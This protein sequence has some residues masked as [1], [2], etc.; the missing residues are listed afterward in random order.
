[1]KPVL[2]F[3]FIFLTTTSTPTVAAFAMNDSTP[4]STATGTTPTTEGWS[5]VEM[6]TVRRET[7]RTRKRLQAEGV[8]GIPRAVS[9]RGQA[10][11][12]DSVNHESTLS[13]PDSTSTTVVTKTIHFQRHGQGYHN[14]VCEMWRE[15]GQP[16]NLDSHDAALNPMKRLEVMDAPLTEVGRQ[17]C[18]ARSAQASR[19][20]PEIMVVSPLLRTL[21]TAQLS[22]GAAHHRAIPWVAHEGCREDLGVL[23]CNKRQTSS[24][25]QS[26]YPNV[27]FSLLVDEHDTL[28]L[29][30][31]HE[32]PLEKATRIYEFLL[33]L[34]D[35]P[36]SEIAVVTHSS[37]LFCMCNAVMEIDD[38]AW[39]RWFF[40]SE[41]RSMQVSF[42]ET[43]SLSES[44]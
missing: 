36:Q 38:D 21:Q 7:A 30:N 43:T 13:P 3:A 28:F 5:A 26:V 40:T 29:P 22:F 6:E 31:R 19:L 12:V 33:Y 4:S 44:T 34:R 23:I 8:V 16:V 37:W 32:M 25:L 42:T 39:S 2:L 18:M 1:M 35:L 17:Q 20:N 9:I 27:D 24:Q 41:I 14:V 10:A 11:P 15:L